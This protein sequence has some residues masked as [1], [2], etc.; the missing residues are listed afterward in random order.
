MLE[1]DYDYPRGT[2]SENRHS[3]P[4]G[5]SAGAIPDV[6][7]GAL[8]VFDDYQTSTQGTGEAMNPAYTYDQ[9][10]VNIKFNYYSYVLLNPIICSAV[11]IKQYA[12]QSYN[13][14]EK[15]LFFKINYFM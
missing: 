12:H 9:A 13:K 5:T 8:C 7:V 3:V 15:L 4:V 10:V 6:P 1:A 2:G 11:Y 14:N